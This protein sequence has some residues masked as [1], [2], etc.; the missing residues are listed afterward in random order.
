QF[1][2]ETS[3]PLEPFGRAGGFIRPGPRRQRGVRGGT[4]VS[5]TLGDLGLGPRR[6]HALRASLSALLQGGWRLELLRLAGACSAARQE[7]RGS[8]DGRVRRRPRGD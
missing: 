7:G 8:D 6:R 2:G 1:I 3:N 5:P 4:R